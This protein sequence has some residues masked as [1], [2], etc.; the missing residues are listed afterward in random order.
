MNGRD[1]LLKAIRKLKAAKAELDPLA[2]DIPGLPEIAEVLGQLLRSP[3]GALVAELQSY[4]TTL[5]S[6]PRPAKAAF[7]LK[8]YTS[9]K[10]QRQQFW[11]QLLI[12]VAQGQ[13]EHPCR[14]IRPR[15]GRRAADLSSVVKKAQRVWTN[16][17]Q[18]YR[19]RTV[20]E[21]LIDAIGRLRSLL[22]R[23]IALQGR[24]VVLNGERIETP[25][26]VMESRLLG[27]L[28]QAGDRG[29]TREDLLNADIPQPAK[30]KSR[31]VQK[32]A[33]SF[34][35]QHIQAGQTGGYIL[36]QP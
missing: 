24:H 25:L 29:V 7:V 35:D 10:P 8:P 34:L 17:I 30:V 12:I 5:W 13:A 14:I 19:A 23:G 33:F 11:L 4:W 3:S 21:Q 6:F 31:L 28:L 1:A 2:T 15:P 27:L 16:Y 20:V 22:P 18:M 36:H 32:P 9:V 26:T